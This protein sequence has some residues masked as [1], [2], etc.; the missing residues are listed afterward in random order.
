MTIAQPFHTRDFSEVLS[1]VKTQTG[2][3]AL[4][5]LASNAR[6][7]LHL[8]N[9]RVQAVFV[10]GRPLRCTEEARCLLMQQFSAPAVSMQF[11][12]APQADLRKGL[13][14]CVAVS[15]THLTLP[16]KRIV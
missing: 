2:I 5:D 16:T 4:R 9:E 14:I 3:L 7:C 6:L 1:D 15:Y 11:E 8:S 13:N 12:E 10:N